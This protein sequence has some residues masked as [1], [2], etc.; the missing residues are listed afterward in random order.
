M[1]RKEDEN[2]YRNVVPR[3]DSSKATYTKNIWVVEAKKETARQRK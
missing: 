1:H 2:C 3:M